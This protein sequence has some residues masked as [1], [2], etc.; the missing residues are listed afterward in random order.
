MKEVNNFLLLVFLFGQITLSSTALSEEKT[1]SNLNGRLEQVQKLIES[2]TG[3]HQ[4]EAGNVPESLQLREQARSIYQEAQSAAQAGQTEQANSLL[5]R[6]SMLMFQAVRAAGKP[7]QSIAKQKADHDSHLAS[8]ETLLE[9][10]QRVRE[11][12]QTKD[13][14]LTPAI[15][16]KLEQA[17]S[18]YANN[19]HPASKKRL[20]EAYSLAKVAIEGLRGGDTLVRELNFASPEEEYEY[21]IDRNETHTMLL[22]VLLKDKQVAQSMATQID[23]F[24]SQAT[25]LRSQAE[26]E[27][28]SGNYKAAIKTLEESTK[29]LVRAIR[30]AGIF[31]PG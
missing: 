29:N 6:A 30:G 17:K 11:E 24:K 1:L 18:L 28:A 31:I 10:Y 8:V 3:A 25:A 12:K 13:E 7:T 20:D 16:Q 19:D 2:S 9:A 14:D 27:A 26:Q 22:T 4:V 23:N 21:E 15:R 5:N